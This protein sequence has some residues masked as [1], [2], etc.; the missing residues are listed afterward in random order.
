MKAKRTIWSTVCAVAVL[1]MTLPLLHSCGIYS[2][3]G[4]SIATDVKTVT[5]NYFEYLASQVNPSLSNQL[6]EALQ[7][8]FIKLTKLELVDIDG[9]LEI[10]GAITGYDVKATAI[11]ANEQ[12]A[13]NRLTV[14]VKITFVNRKYPEE[15]FESKS[16]SAYQDFDS[17]NS[18]DAVEATLCEDIVEQLCEDM[19]NATVAQW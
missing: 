2:F 3:T 13:Q 4:T 5:I 12:A 17:S 10:V 18:L 8:K 7:E 6:T 14:N 16:F 19:F 11:T 15:S 1:L 9:D